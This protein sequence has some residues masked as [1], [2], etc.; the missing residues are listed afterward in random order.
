[1]QLILILLI[2][3]FDKNLPYYLDIF[4]ILSGFKATCNSLFINN[5]G[6]IFQV[7][8]TNIVFALKILSGKPYP[9]FLSS[10]GNPQKFQISKEALLLT[11]NSKREPF[12]KNAQQRK[13]FCE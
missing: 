1:M 7:I 4:E 6:N 11:T 2:C 5:D 13:T 8:L 3:E 12:S 10:I 9:S